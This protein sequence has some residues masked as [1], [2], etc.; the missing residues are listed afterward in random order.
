MTF[1]N[2]GTCQP[3]TFSN[4]PLST[5]LSVYA[6]HVL[7][8]RRFFTTYSGC[9]LKLDL[10]VPGSALPTARLWHEIARSRLLSLDR[11]LSLF[12]RPLAVATF[13]SLHCFPLFLFW[14]SFSF[15]A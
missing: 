10:L 1:G 13:P 3:D 12:L 7:L 5:R 6:L 11:M 4:Y 8:V 15:D 9:F 14:Q 2:I